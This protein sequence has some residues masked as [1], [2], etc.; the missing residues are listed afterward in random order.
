VTEDNEDSRASRILRRF[1]FLR[2][3]AMPGLILMGALVGTGFLV[4]L[5]T[6][7]GAAGTLYVPL[8]MPHIV[9]G[10]LGGLALIGLGAVLIYVQWGRRDDAAKRR[11][12]DELLDEAAALVAMEPEIRKRFAPK[13]APARRKR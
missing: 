1:G 7:V 3:P 8:Q 12:T 2:D 10:G 4:L 5:L 9:S 6:W 13:T 11:L